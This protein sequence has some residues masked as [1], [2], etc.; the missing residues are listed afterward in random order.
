[1]FSDTHRAEKQF[2]CTSQYHIKHTAFT[3]GECHFIE[4]E[5]KRLKNLIYLSTHSLMVE[6]VWNLFDDGFCL[7]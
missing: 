2:F 5:R 1:M 6:D 4:A 7:F 3:K